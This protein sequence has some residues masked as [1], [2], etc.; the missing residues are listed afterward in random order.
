MIGLKSGSGAL[1]KTSKTN[2]QDP[3]HNSDSTSNPIHEDLLQG[4][5]DE[6]FDRSR[7]FDEFLNADSPIRR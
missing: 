5:L 1:N 6:R 3:G 7:F 2:L 4:Y